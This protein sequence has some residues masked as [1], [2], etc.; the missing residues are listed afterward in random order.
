MRWDIGDGQEST[1]LSTLALEDKHK[2]RPLRGRGVEDLVH[3]L[4]TGEPNKEVC[5][6]MADHHHHILADLKE[7]SKVQLDLGW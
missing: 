4:A 6:A 3:I 5:W 1:N 2:V 7:M